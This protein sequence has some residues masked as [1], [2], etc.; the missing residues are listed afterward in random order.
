MLT[1]SVSVRNFST[2][3]RTLEWSDCSANSPQLYSNDSLSGVP[4]FD[5]DRR[6]NPDPDIGRWFC[7]G[8]LTSVDLAAGDTVAPQGLGAQMKVARVVGDSLPPGLYYIATVIRFIDLATGGSTELIRVPA[9][10][11]RLRR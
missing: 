2:R 8:R 10:T 6:P 11:A 9:G 1:V 4:I 7:T 5:W 3:K